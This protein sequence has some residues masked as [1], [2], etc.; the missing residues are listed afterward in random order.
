MCFLQ[1]YYFCVY[2]LDVTPTITR[3]IPYSATIVGIEWASPS[4]ML[5]VSRYNIYVS[6]DGAP[7]DSISVNGSAN[8]YNIT[9][10]QPSSNY[11]IT[12]TV[13]FNDDEESSMSVPVTVRTLDVICDPPC[14]FG[15]ECVTAPNTCDCSSITNTGE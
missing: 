1:L 4:V 10:L 7:Q 2:F 13:M 15:G 12:I 6:G 11:T 3:A 14:P 8:T 5:T 9:N